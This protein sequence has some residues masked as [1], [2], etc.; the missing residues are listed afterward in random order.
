MSSLSAS[1]SSQ[2]AAGG[3]NPRLSQ[4]TRK[5]AQEKQVVNSPSP[6]FRI[7]VAS[8]LVK[9][10]NVL[11]DTGALAL[12]LP[13]Q[14]SESLTP[15]GGLGKETPKPGSWLTSDRPCASDADPPPYIHTPA[16]KITLVNGPFF[17]GGGRKKDTNFLERG[18]AGEQLRESSS[19][20]KGGQKG[21]QH[22]FELLPPS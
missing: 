19:I 7:G 5:Y 16:F 2:E 4:A 1:T 17:G 9:A 14:S 20:W 15:Q 11:P 8:A 22:L 10:A 21:R 12:L 13:P 3:A 6:S 18:G